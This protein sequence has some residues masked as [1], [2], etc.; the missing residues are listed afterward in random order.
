MDIPVR[1]DFWCDQY[2]VDQDFCEETTMDNALNLEQIP[3][4]PQATILHELLPKLWQQPSVQ[5]LWL[6][7][8]LARG[9]RIAIAMSISMW[10]LPTKS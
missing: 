6:E 4:W 9:T 3:S 10:A 7:G 8:S 2:P 5:A 1:S